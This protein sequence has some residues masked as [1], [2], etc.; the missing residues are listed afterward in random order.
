M[1]PLPLACAA[2]LFCTTQLAMANV[3]YTF[4][5]NGVTENY[6]QQ[7]SALFN[8]SNDG[9]SLSITLT[10][11]V[12][13]TAAILSEITG[14]D[15]TMSAAPASISLV[16]VTGGSVIDCTNS[17]SPC[18]PGTGSS[19][20]GWGILGTGNGASLGA[21]FDGGSFSYQ[22]YGIVNTNYLSAVAGGQLDAPSTN[23]LLVGPITFTFALTG[24]PYAPEVSS[25]VFKFGDPVGVTAV[26]EPKSLALFA[27]ALLAAG[28]VARRRQNRS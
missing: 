14:L 12:S 7:G 24:M 3:Q 15:F 27:V 25:V 9:S 17:A 13:P 6:S 22:P 5:A 16:S 8:F 20:Y 10:D 28:F 11:T 26:P 4:Y 18:P 21:G 23:P 19:P 2:A 1:K